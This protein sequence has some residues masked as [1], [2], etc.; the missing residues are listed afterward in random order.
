[1]KAVWILVYNDNES[2]G[3]N[4][5]MDINFF[6]IR[7]LRLDYKP[8]TKHTAKMSA[9]KYTYVDLPAWETLCMHLVPCC[10][11]SHDS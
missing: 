2:P 3:A 1:M 10:V 5:S 9:A 6:V 11:D 8:G 4:P 7:S